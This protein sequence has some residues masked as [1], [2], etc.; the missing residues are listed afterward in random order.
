MRIFMI[1]INS[2]FWLWLFIVP[3]GVL[4]FLAVWLYFRSSGNLPY[5][6]IIGAIGVTLGIVLAEYVRKKYGLDHF[7]GRLSATPELDD[8]NKVEEGN[9]SKNL[10]A[11]SK[12][13]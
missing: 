5:S 13:N 9:D 3:T 1:F 12:V 7:F 2:I 6:I 10:A 11:K 4:G 8:F